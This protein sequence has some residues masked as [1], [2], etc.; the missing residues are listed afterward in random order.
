MILDGALRSFGTPVVA[1]RVL[2][3]LRCGLVW[4]TG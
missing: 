3:Q 2:P 4:G 1:T